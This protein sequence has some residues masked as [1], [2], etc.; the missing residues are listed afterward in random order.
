MC[1]ASISSSSDRSNRIVVLV[2]AG[3]SLVM[4]PYVCGDLSCGLLFRVVIICFCILGSFQRSSQALH[5]QLCLDLRG[6]LHSGLPVPL[7]P[8]MSSVCMTLS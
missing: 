1:Y 6:V 2:V 8:L 7:C 3:M 4:D 5:L